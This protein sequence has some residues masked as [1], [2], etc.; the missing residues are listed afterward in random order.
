MTTCPQWGNN[1]DM[2]DKAKKAVKRKHSADMHVRFTPEQKALCE[3]AA[4]YEGASLSSWIRTKLIAAARET[5][6]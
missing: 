5:L 3:K 6:K 1:G 2:K 4:E